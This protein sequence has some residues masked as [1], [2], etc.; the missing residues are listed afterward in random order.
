[1]SY[2]VSSRRLFMLQLL[3]EC[4]VLLFY[5]TFVSLV[6]S[7]NFLDFLLKFAE[8][9]IHFVLPKQIILLK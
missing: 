7:F 4:L 2:Y 8:G 9:S 3:K 6:K 1:V 5:V